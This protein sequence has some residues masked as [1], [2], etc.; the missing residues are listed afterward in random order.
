MYSVVEN[1]KLSVV[2]V[3][4]GGWRNSYDVNAPLTKT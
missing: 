4:R 2:A 1:G 3:E